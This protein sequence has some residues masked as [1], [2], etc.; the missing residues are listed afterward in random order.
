M[1]PLKLGLIPVSVLYIGASLLHII[2]CSCQ[3]NDRVNHLSQVI[4]VQTCN[5][6]IK[7][8]KVISQS[9]Y[10]YPIRG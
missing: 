10:K 4:A 2:D 3:I 9:I 7:H 1:I 5:G 8:I 6:H